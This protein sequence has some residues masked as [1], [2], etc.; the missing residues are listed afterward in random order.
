MLGGC[1]GFLL[2]CGGVFSGCSQRGLLFLA[3]CRLLIVVA[4]L[5]VE[6]TFQCLHLPGCRAQTQ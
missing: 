6:H 2:L 3:V 4:S 1:A 5:P